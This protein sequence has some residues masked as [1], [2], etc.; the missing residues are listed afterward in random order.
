MHIV[1]HQSNFLRENK[2]S[3]G[4]RLRKGGDWLPEEPKKMIRG[5]ELLILSPD[6]V[7]GERG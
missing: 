3:F 4:K 1:K 7:G 5:L 6:L 2:V